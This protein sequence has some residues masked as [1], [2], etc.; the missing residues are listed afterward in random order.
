MGRRHS[1]RKREVPPPTCVPSPGG[2]M[3]LSP[4][5]VYSRRIVGWQTSTGL[6]TDLALDALKMAIWQRKRTG[7]DLSG[8]VHH[9]RPRRAVP[10][11][12]LRQ[13]LA[14]CEAVAPVGSKGDSFRL[15][16]GRGAQA[17]L[18]KAELIL[19]PGTLGGHRRRPCSPPPSGCTGAG[20]IRPH[21]AIGMRTPAEHEAAWAPDAGHDHH[22]QEQPQ[23]ATSTSR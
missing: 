11:H 8:L 18:Y 2:S 20:T 13:A 14:D 10:S 4:A 1:P 23:P 12:P 17:P 22:R 15:R 21:S 6:C 7:A 5:D 3:W 19:W 16:S 9:L